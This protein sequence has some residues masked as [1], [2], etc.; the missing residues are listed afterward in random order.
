MIINIVFRI[1]T[2]FFTNY[3][4][5]YACDIKVI[6]L[7]ATRGLGNSASQLQHKLEEQH[8]RQWLTQTVRYLADC[9]G[10]VDSKLTASC[11]FAQPPAQI[12]TPKYAWLQSVYCIDVMNRID[13]VKAAITSTFGTILKMDSTKK[14]WHTISCFNLS[15]I[16][17]FLL[18]VFAAMTVSVWS[19]IKWQFFQPLCFRS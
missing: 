13:E 3:I 5:R 1:I 19:L 6:T 16:C 4:F 10:F 7:L 12:P 14:V 11:V 18:H 8:H 17:M 15:F 2:M 9:K